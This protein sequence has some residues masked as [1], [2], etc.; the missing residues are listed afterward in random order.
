MYIDDIKWGETRMEIPIFRHDFKNPF[1]DKEVYV[2][3]FKFHAEEDE[4]L[5]GSKQEQ[6]DEAIA[7]F[8]E[9]IK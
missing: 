2:F 9:R 5:Y 3:N 4:D 6:I 7:D 1:N 8:I